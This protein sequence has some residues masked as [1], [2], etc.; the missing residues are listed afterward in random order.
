MLKDLLELDSKNAKAMSRKLTCLLKMGKL[1]ELEGE[2]KYLKNSMDTFDQEEKEDEYKL[3]ERT[4]AQME[5]ELAVKRKSD[6]K[7]VKNVFSKGSLYDDKPD[8]KEEE[9]IEE[10]PEVK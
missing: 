4:I 3:L 6:E 8:V 2:V 9:E 10:S 5:R 1:D 7:F